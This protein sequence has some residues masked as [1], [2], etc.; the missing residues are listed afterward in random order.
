[1]GDD[2]TGFFPSLPAAV[3]LEQFSDDLSHHLEI[4][5]VHAGFRFVQEH[6]PGILGQQL[7]KFGALDLT[8]GKAVVDFPVQ[9]RGE[10]IGRG[11]D[12]V[13][14]AGPRSRPSKCL[15]VLTPRMVGGR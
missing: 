5:Q 2:Q 10:I 13:V 6:H 1:M 4:L 12:L 3:F 15:S 7:Q 8:A 14:H 9:E 11:Q